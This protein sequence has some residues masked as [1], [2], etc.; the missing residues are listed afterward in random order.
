MSKIQTAAPQLDGVAQFINP[1]GPSASVWDTMAPTTVKAF[2]DAT[3]DQSRTHEQDTRR[4][5]SQMLAEYRLDPQKFG[6]KQ[7]TIDEAAKRAGSLGL[8][9]IV[10]RVVGVPFPGFP[11]TFQSPY[12]LYIDGYHALQDRERTENH[13][14]GWADDEFLKQYGE[15]YFPL[16]QSQS[17]NNGGVQATAEGVTAS[18][19]YK[20]LIAKYGVEAGKADP[21]LIRLIVGQE[22]EGEYNDSAHLWQEQ[23]EISPASGVNYRDYAN[24]Q[25]AQAKADAD[26]G[27]LKYRQFM[28]NLDATALEQ[29]FRTYADS[30][31]LVA[32]RKEFVQNLQQE[33]ASWYVDWSQRDSTKFTRD[34]NALGE[35]ASSGKFGPMRTDMVGVKQ[36]L[37]LRQ[38]FEEETAQYGISPGS[39]DAQPFRQEFT[40]AVADLVSQN[41]QFAEWSYYTFLERDPYLEPVTS[42]GRPSD[43]PAA[44]TDWGIG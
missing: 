26:L 23:H 9:K 41:S 11:A 12:Q 31:E 38:A 10:N 33:N 14:H 20:S 28:N 22:G 40:D 39:A 24:P 15:T 7:P 36:Y 18:G 3:N 16:V 19:K 29:G 1:Y 43:Q 30:D 27:W 37:A 34:L 13:P 2:A 42:Q 8:L 4:I 17:L 21:N 6:G 35:I 44:P 5:W 32:T 25:A